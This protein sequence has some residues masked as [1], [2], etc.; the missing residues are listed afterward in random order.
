MVPVE[1]MLAR[2]DLIIGRFMQPRFEILGLDF[3]L[4]PIGAPIRAALMPYAEFKRGSAQ[5]F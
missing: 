3:T 4:D 5:G 1:L 2:I